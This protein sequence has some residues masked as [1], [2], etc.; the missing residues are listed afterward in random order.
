MTT[1]KSVQ[2]LHTNSDMANMLTSME[3]Y[4]ESARGKFGYAIARNI[5]KLNDACMEFLQARQELIEQFGEQTKDENGNI[6][7]EFSI[8][9]GTS[10]CDEFLKQLGE[11]ANIEHTVEIYKIPYD[12]L[13]EELTAKDLLA[14]DWM[15]YDE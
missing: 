13:P 14:L 6:T 10:A 4:V 9:L 2:E 7:G 3:P 8:K 1:G 11:Y 15:L 12:I 5:R